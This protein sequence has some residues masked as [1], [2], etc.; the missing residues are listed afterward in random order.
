MEGAVASASD[1]KSLCRKAGLTEE[2]GAKGEI[3]FYRLIAT[4]APCWIFVTNS[5]IRQSVEST[6]GE[7][8]RKVAMVA[9]ALSV[10]R[11]E[12]WFV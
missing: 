5:V 12:Q 3:S 7:V 1:G 11:L 4:S 6:V 8:I 2:M 10:Y 9:I